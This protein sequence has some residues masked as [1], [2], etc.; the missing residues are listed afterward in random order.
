MPKKR[1]KQQ[2]ADNTEKLL[3]RLINLLESS[4][5]IDLAYKGF[6][7]NSIAKILGRDIH[8]VVDLLKPLNKEIQKLR[9]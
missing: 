5:I 3:I 7:Y 2:P 4:I 1:V 9:R 8:R 6:G